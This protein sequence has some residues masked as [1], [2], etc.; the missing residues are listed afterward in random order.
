MI[1]QQMKTGAVGLGRDTLTKVELDNDRAAVCF[2]PLPL[3][4]A[5]A[6]DFDYFLK[7]Y[8]DLADDSGDPAEQIPWAQNLYKH[9]RGEPASN[10]LQA[11][12][13]PCSVI[14]SGHTR[15]SM[16]WCTDIA[17]TV[18]QRLGTEIP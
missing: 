13:R 14:A 7:W 17:R 15:D 1:L 3:A 16:L 8:R 11:P 12:I 6:F 4:I 10:N 5:S 18:G 9:L 2:V